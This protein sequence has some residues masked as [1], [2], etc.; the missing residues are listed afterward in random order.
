MKGIIS[1][2]IE[3]GRKELAWQLGRTQVALSNLVSNV[4][5]FRIERDADFVCKRLWLI[6]YPLYGAVIDAALSLPPL[7]NVTLKDGVTS[8]GLALVSGPARAVVLDTDPLKAQAAYMGLG[9]PFLVRL[10]NSIFAEVVNPDAAV[11]PWVG[12]LYLVGEGYKNYPGLPEE[13]PNKIESMAFPFDLN[14]SGD[15]Q[16]PSA[17]AQNI[18]GQSITITNNGQGKMLVKSLVFNIVDAAGVDV[19]AALAPCLA[20]QISDSTSGMK[21]WIEN[22]N[23]KVAGL[24]ACPALILNMHGSFLPFNQPRYVDPNGVVRVQ[25]S[26]A[27]GLAPALAYLNGACTWP[28][29]MQV[30]LKGALLPR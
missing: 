19:T 14:A 12:D 11:N 27:S 4:V 26:W 8:T 9:C 15:I 2:P 13:I 20:L 22:S 5:S 3:Q 30:T 28:V 7:A 6:Q 21:P 29:R 16:D 10:N 18:E 24:I 1:L 17:A 23:A 25:L